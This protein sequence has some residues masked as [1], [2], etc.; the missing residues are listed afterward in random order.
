MLERAAA[1][2]G[3]SPGWRALLLAR[4]GELARTERREARA[5]EAWR[6]ALAI[7]PGC[8]T[9][10]ARDRGGGGGR[11]PAAQGGLAR[12]DG[13]RVRDA[14]PAAR[15]A[16]RVP[17][18]RGRWPAPRR[19]PACWRSWRASVGWTSTS[20]TSS[21]AGRGRRGDGG[22]ARARLAVA[23]AAAPGH[24]LAGD[25]AR[26]LRRRGAATRRARSRRC[27]RWQRRLPDDP[28][29]LVALGKLLH[30]MG[31]GERRAR[32]AARGAGA[33]APGSGAQALRR[34]PGRR[35]ARRCRARPT[36]SR[37]ATPTTPARWSPSREGGRRLTGEAAIVLLDRRVVRV[38]RNGLSRTFA[39]RIVEV[40]TER[41]AEE[42][43][44]F[45]VHY[46]PGSEEV[47]IRQARVYRR[48]DRRRGPDPRGD[49]S[50]RRGSVGA[51]VRPLL[52]QSRGGGAL[53]GAASRRRRRDPVPGRRRGEREPARRLFRRPAVRRRDDPE[54]ALGLHA[55]RS[56]Q[57]AHL[58]QRA[59]RR[60]ART[61]RLRRRGGP[62][63][64]IRRRQRRRRS[65]RSRRC[66]A[67]RRSRPTCTSAPM[68]P[69]RRS[70]PGTGTWSRSSWSPTTRSEPPRA[71][72]VA[73]RH[74]RR[75]AGARGLRLRR[76]EHALRG[77][78]V[79]DPRLQALQGDA[80]ARASLRRLQG[81]GVA[82]DRAPAR[83]GRGRGAGPGAHAPGRAPR[84]GAGV[85]R[86]LRSRHRLRARSSTAISTGP[87]SSPGSPSCP[88]R[89][90]A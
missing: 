55:H 31:K 50:Q 28:P 40:R 2:E 26:P 21:R 38:H 77:P 69:G 47:E 6:E 7:D 89:I 48:D 82:H 23:A 90:R 3:I 87:P 58:R 1:L 66:R 62:R 29:T 42:N 52:R 75:G 14:G 17:A 25:R 80:G 37:A 45:A 32:A 5:L 34:S 36:S 61:E 70:V 18:L 74:V 12:V 84:S 76:Q 71:A 9:G 43:K 19:R 44:E 86:D 81:Q 10:H 68:R 20:C 24:R 13:P 83:G 16:G 4:L 79:R 63:L 30:R 11:G 72:L 49:R 51:L 41:G 39:Q 60:G 33:A 59:A 88:R 54:A 35:D 15:A 22:E 64:P 53:R 27:P 57:P 78:R 56:R 8:W 73:Q 67:S 46:T 85:A 65:T